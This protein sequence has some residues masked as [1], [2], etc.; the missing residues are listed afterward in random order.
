MAATDASFWR[1]QTVFRAVL[2][3][4][5]MSNQNVMSTPPNLL[6]SALVAPWMF[7]LLRRTRESGDPVLPTYA[8]PRT[9][10]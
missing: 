7:C 4:R 5:S 10:P 1:L 3:F 2:R 6:G 8:R 9:G